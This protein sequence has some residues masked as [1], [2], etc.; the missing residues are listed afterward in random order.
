MRDAPLAEPAPEKEA[1]ATLLEENV[2]TGSDASSVQPSAPLPGTPLPIPQGW[3]TED[4]LAVSGEFLLE[5]QDEPAVFILRGVRI[6]VSP[7]AIAALRPQPHQLLTVTLSS[8]GQGAVFT[9]DGMEID[10]PYVLV[11]PVPVEVSVTGT[12]AV[13][14]HLAAGSLLAA[15]GVAAQERPSGGWLVATL[16]A[17]GAMTLCAG[18]YLLRKGFWLRRRL[19]RKKS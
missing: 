8:D 12:S 3:Q 11:P 19:P 1:A 9:L 2:T 14:P 18:S 10:L 7:E 13:A 15:D 17:S 6:V 16:A 5:M 4:A